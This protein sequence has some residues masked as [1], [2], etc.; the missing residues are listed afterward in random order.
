MNDKIK[1][2]NLVIEKLINVGPVSI[3][4]IYSKWSPNH[5]AQLQVAVDKIVCLN[6]ILSGVIKL[7]DNV[8]YVQLNAHCNFVKVLNFNKITNFKAMDS[9]SRVRYME[10][11][12][13]TK[14]EPMNRGSF[15]INN[16]SKL[17]QVQIINMSDITAIGFT[18]SH[19]IVDGASFYK[20]I[21][22]IS[23]EMNGQL[24]PRLS[25]DVSIS[26]EINTIGTKMLT[27][28]EL[29]FFEHAFMRGLQ[30]LIGCKEEKPLFNHLIA[31]YKIAELKLSLKDESV[32][33]L[34]A[35]DI[36]ISSLMEALINSEMI[37][38]MVDMRRR[39]KRID[40]NTMG[41][42]TTTSILF[43]EKCMNPNV[44]R[45]GLKDLDWGTPTLHETLKLAA[46]KFTFVSN[47][48]G[49][50]KS[51]CF[52]DCQLQ[53]SLL[54]GEIVRLSPNNSVFITD[55]NDDY[56]CVQ[57]NIPQNELDLTK[58]FGKLIKE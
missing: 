38:L 12:F 36:I 28:Y 35:N 15:Q 24:L 40:E 18:M 46:G 47:H 30:Y 20:L 42:L 33:F 58:K 13:I 19:M 9:Q 2:S 37:F 11:H 3:C 34:S 41:N 17:F 54:S 16:N 8:G 57:H 45:A 49:L 29:W 55:F 7:E 21:E 32:E 44:V 26:N 4:Q 23:L 31:K 56:F 10:E 5:T 1:L 48:A 39:D 43:G 51:I 27:E 25:W 52:N 50:Q 14:L 53:G 6:P 22:C